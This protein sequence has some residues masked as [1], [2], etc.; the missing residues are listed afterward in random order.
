MRPSALLPQRSSAVADAVRR[1]SRQPVLLINDEHPLLAA[2]LPSIAEEPFGACE[3]LPAHLACVLQ[4]SAQ[5][6]AQPSLG[7]QAHVQQALVCAGAGS[8]GKAAGPRSGAASKQR[9][10]QAC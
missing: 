4:P 2:A 9:V 8:A 6:S 3:A 5:P 10:L 1:H 7:A